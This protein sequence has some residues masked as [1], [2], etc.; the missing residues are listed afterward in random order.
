MVPSQ[1]IEPW[2]L[3]LFL[4]ITLISRDSLRSI[5]R[6]FVGKQIKLRELGPDFKLLNRYSYD[7]PR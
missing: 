7:F 1:G 6:L 5:D 4:L 3:I 2:V